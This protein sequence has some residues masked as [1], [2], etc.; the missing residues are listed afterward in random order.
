MSKLYYNIIDNTIIEFVIPKNR[1]N[2]GIEVDIV[3]VT[4]DGNYINIETLY[5][6]TVLFEE[7]F[8]RLTSIEND[9]IYDYVTDLLKIVEFFKHILEN[10][11]R[12]INNRYAE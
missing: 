8:N 6:E 3:R 7:D 9:Y 12:F 10:D 4:L 5:N 2:N 11:E 1:T